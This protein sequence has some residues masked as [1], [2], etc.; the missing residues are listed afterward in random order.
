M[1]IP[2][3][4]TAAVVKAGVFLRER[5]AYRTSWRSESRKG[6]PRALFAIATPVGVM[7]KRLAELSWDVKRKAASV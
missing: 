4:S 3:V 2:S 7:E 6:S 1:P 5:S